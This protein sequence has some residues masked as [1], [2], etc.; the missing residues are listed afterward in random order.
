MVMDWKKVRCEA[1]VVGLVEPWLWPALIHCTVSS[2]LSFSPLIIFW[3]GE[4][5]GMIWNRE[6]KRLCRAYLLL[7]VISSECFDM[8]ENIS[9]VSWISFLA[10][11]WTL[12]RGCV[13]LVLG[14]WTW[15]KQQKQTTY[16]YKTWLNIVKPQAA[17]FYNSKSKGLHQICVKRLIVHCA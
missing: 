15:N 16:G 14:L 12:R 2:R 11:R 13:S 10:I 1:H 5:N 4:W 7:G 6:C 17:Y 3:E 9:T 8:H